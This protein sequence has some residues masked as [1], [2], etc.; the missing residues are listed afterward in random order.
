[1]SG[2]RSCCRELIRLGDCSR[3]DAAALGVPA[4]CHCWRPPLLIVPPSCDFLQLAHFQG[5]FP[6]FPQLLSSPGLCG[7]VWQCISALITAMVKGPFSGRAGQQGGECCLLHHQRADPLP[8]APLL[9]FPPP[10]GLLLLRA[11]AAC[12]SSA[13]CVVIRSSASPR[14]HIC[15]YWEGFLPVAAHP[16]CIFSNNS[17]FV[18]DVLPNLLKS[19]T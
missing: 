8:A 4:P 11:A 12:F 13:A 5:P 17:S 10:G 7:C 19:G 16:H 1:M 9:I 3:R 15:N 18:S 14:Q 6:Y 2:V